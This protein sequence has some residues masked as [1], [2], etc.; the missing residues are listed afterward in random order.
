MTPQ[1]A[2]DH[3]GI[4]YDTVVTMAKRTAKGQVKFVNR[5]LH[6]VRI[7]KKQMFIRRADVEKYERF[8]GYKRPVRKTAPVDRGPGKVK[9][10]APATPGPCQGDS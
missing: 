2:A 1:E 6:F 3:I 4:T 10:C 7:G 5:Q 8:A 9:S